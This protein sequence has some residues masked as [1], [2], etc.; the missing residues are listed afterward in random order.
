M[1]SLREKNGRDIE[2]SAS[3]V[4]L[5]GS[6]ASESDSPTHEEIAL[7]AYEI[8]ISRGAAEGRDVEDW[9]EAE[10][11]LAARSRTEALKS[12]STTA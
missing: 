1:P 4:A 9:L 6:R 10:Q 7:G 2:S 12:R 11:R 5:G 8:Y 3:S